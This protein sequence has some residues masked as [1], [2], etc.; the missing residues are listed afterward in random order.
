MPYFSQVAMGGLNKLYIFGDNYKTNDG[1]GARDYIHVVDLAVGHIK[2]LQTRKK[3]PGVNTYNLGSGK[4]YSVLEVIATFEKIIGKKIPYEIVE[5]RQGDVA[6]NYADCH[7]ANSKLDWYAK[8]DLLKM[9]EDTW[10][11]ISMN[12]E[13]YL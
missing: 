9:C 4:G 7:F 6:I 1:T 2:A 13:G 5:R 12:P 8:R 11:W 3:A 10:K